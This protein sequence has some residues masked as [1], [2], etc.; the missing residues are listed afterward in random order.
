MNYGVAELRE[1]N[2]DELLHSIILHTPYGESGVLVTAASVNIT[3]TIGQA[4]VITIV[5]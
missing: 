4:D 2:Y 5:R 3:V 1:V